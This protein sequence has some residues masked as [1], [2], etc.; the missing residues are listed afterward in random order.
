MLKKRSITILLF[1]GLL[2][3]LC[4]C[5]VT[6][7][8]T[9]HTEPVL[10][11]AE[12]RFN[13]A[14]VAQQQVKPGESPT[15]AELNLPGL[16]LAGWLDDKGNYVDFSQQKLMADTIYYAS[17]FPVLDQ[18]KPFLFADAVGFLHPDDNLTAQ[19]L[20]EGLRALATEEAK[21]YFPTLPEGEDAVTPAALKTLLGVFFSQSQ[22]DAAVQLTGDTV[23]RREFAVIMCALLGR[24]EEKITLAEGCVIPKD[25]QRETENCN[26]L[27]EA[28]VAH[29][30]AE[31]GTSWD[32]VQLPTGYEPGLINIKGWLYYV[33]EDGYF[34]TDGKV[35]TLT[36]GSDG[37]FTCGDKELDAM[38]AEILDV[39]LKENEEAT[40]LEILRAA[41]LYTRDSFT[42]LRRD[43]YNFGD[44]GWQ[45]GDA[46][47]MI[48]TKRGNCYSFAAVFWALARGLGYDAKAVSGTCTKTYQPHSWVILQ[49]EGVQYFCDPEW[50][51]AYI[52]R[53]ELDKDMFM[54]TMDR[55]WYWTY[56]WEE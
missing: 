56:V 2:C 49:Y 9:E 39:I 29:T 50:E 44:D 25:I 35:G 20:A 40:P 36:F 21:T 12:F 38:V 18:H 26:I 13:G 23:T 53:G 3:L 41:Y 30:V 42:Y 37:R 54:I 17:V 47:K 15:A 28:S 27:L 32:E 48:T 10:Y 1:A 6:P 11:K 43:P 7:Q 16:T 52:E 34:L 14:V 55:I 45:I 24:S 46:K 4:A 31:E 19:A 33:K 8:S 5:T 51:Y 22:V